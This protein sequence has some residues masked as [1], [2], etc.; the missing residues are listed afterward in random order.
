MLVTKRK[1]KK[2]MQGHCTVHNHDS[3]AGSMPFN[4]PLVSLLPLP[5]PLPL[6]LEVEPG[7]ASCQGGILG[8]TS[9]WKEDV[10]G[11]DEPAAP[12]GVELPVPA[13]ESCAPAPSPEGDRPAAVGIPDGGAAAAPREMRSDLSDLSSVCTSEREAACA[14]RCL[15]N[16]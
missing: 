1:P 5:L 3:V 8:L 6:P 10:F 13:S 4:I 11:L 7:C 12:V 2:G 16:I 14:S 9:G 15:S